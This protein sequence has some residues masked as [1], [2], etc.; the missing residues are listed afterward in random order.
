[1]I[2]YVIVYKNPYILEQ[3]IG[4]FLGRLVKFLIVKTFH[5]AI[6][7]AEYIEYDTYDYDES[8]TRYE[9]IY[10]SRYSTGIKKS[11]FLIEFGDDIWK[12]RYKRKK[13]TTPEIESIR[14][15]L[16]VCGCLYS[17]TYPWY[18]STLFLYIVGDFCSIE[19]DRYI[20]KRKCEYKQK[21]YSYIYP[22][23]IIQ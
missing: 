17:W 9:K 18:I 10:I 22:S 15:L 1:M 23:W 5:I 14:C 6:H 16:E 13:S 21:K 12:Y 7:T 4:I 3:Y 11:K 2:Y 20:E 8:S 19:C